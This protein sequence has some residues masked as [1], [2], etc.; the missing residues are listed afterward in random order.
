MQIVLCNKFVQFLSCSV[1]LAPNEN[2]KFPTF[3][4]YLP[5]LSSISKS[6]G[7]IDPVIGVGDSSSHPVSLMD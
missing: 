7:L 5:P 3:R 4:K 1:M 2:E 6:V